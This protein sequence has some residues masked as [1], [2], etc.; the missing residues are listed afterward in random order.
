V[1]DYEKLF[2]Q[3][4]R[5]LSSAQSTA[6]AWWLM[7]QLES[8]EALV[9]RWPCGPVSH[10]V[11][12]GVYRKYYITCESL[13][14]ARKGLDDRPG[15]ASRWGT[16]EPE[17]RDADDDASTEVPPRVFCVEWLSGKHP[18]LR[19]LL[20]RLVFSP[21][22]SDDVGLDLD[23]EEEA[24]DE[25][26]SLDLEFPSQHSYLTDWQMA[27]KRLIEAPRDLDL[28]VQAPS[29]SLAA[30][31]SYFRDDFR[32]YEDE[33]TKAVSRALV[34]WNRMTTHTARRLRNPQ[35]GIDS[36][37]SSRPAGPASYPDVVAS[38]RR[39]WLRCAA[40]NRDR[41][42]AGRVAP[43]TFV[44]QWLLEAGRADLARILA[45]MPYWPL[46][47]DETRNWT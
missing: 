38:I 7:R 1:N 25:P 24:G 42:D 21:I 36:V 17:E 8:G 41:E 6:E 16:S 30:T 11:V 34:W 29:R 9:Q 5:A 18:A 32:L 27:V 45:P 15:G 43:Q 12:I 14:R 33:L 19:T 39:G 10:P 3:Y 4:V 28:A 23:D 35:R 37:W 31:D 22:G 44:L 47:L 46:G 26:V 20:G 40:I 13:N 2:S